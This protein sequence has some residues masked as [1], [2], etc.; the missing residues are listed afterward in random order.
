MILV[1]YYCVKTPRQISVGTR[2]QTYQSV[3]IIKIR[4]IYKPAKLSMIYIF[5]HTLE[6]L[7]DTLHDCIKNHNRF[8][9][10]SL[11][12]FLMPKTDRYERI[13]I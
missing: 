4:R 6:N 8:G 13:Y 2:I 5:K 11:R 10:N 7:I 9:I 3:A 1:S 12:T